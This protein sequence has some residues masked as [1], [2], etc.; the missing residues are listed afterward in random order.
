MHRVAMESHA[1]CFMAGDGRL[2]LVRIYQHKLMV[3]VELDRILV[4]IDWELAHPY[5]FLQALASG[6]S[7]HAPLHLATNA[8]FSSKLRFHFENWWTKLPGFIEAVHKGWICPDQASDPF[9]RLDI[10]LKRTA[11]EIQ[12]WSQRNVGQL[13]VQLLVARTI[14][15]WLDRAQEERTLTAQEAQLK[16]SGYPL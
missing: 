12:S 4:A 13:K 14:V 15:Q 11:R 10:L 16:Y 6:M 2:A 5:C 3:A 8:A 7:N 1:I 9:T